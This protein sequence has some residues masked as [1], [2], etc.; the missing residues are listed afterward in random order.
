M[1]MPDFVPTNDAPR[2]PACVVVVEPVGGHGGMDFSNHALCSALA[3]EGWAP[4][5]LTSQAMPETVAGYDAWE[6]YRGVF[7]QAPKWQ[8]GLRHVFATVRGLRRARRLGAE[9]AHFHVFHVGMLQYFGIVVS[10]LMGM[11]VVLSAHDVGSFRAGE[12][13]WMLNLTYKASNAIIAHSGRG[14]QA[15]IEMFAV[16]PAKTF[17][18]PLGNYEGFL[19]PLPDSKA[20]KA[21]FGYGTDDFVILFFGQIKRVKRLDLL[22]RATARARGRG[23]ANIRLLVAGSSADSDM[24]ALQR[25]IV[26]EGLGDIVQ[27]HARYI[28]NEDLP[29]YF[30]AA[31]LSALP[32]ENIFQSGVILLA[33]SNDVPVLTSDIPGM[34]EIIEHGRTGLTFRSGD[35]EDLTDRLIEASRGDWDM[36]SLAEAARDLVRTRHG[37]ANCARISIDAYD[38]ARQA[39]DTSTPG[40][41]RAGNR[42]A[43]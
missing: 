6:V 41:D 18:V 23:A 37:W 15:L 43:S 40:V 11:R 12:S 25:L 10:R 31:D 30:A 29:W 7:G 22:L 35:V 19:P 5:L 28:S 27:L 14:R 16:P 2:R 38:F 24:D 4:L 1:N 9:V 36:T 8:R 42:I 34:L 3:A 20:A 32:Y 13:T 39:A 26:D 21:S 33:M 17:A